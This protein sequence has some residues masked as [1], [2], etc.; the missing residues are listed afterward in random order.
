MLTP[1]R[2]DYAIA[3]TKRTATWARVAGLWGPRVVLVVPLMTPRSTAQ[4]MACHA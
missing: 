3:S 2:V 4:A 1:K